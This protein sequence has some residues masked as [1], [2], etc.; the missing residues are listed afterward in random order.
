M[1][2]ERHELAIPGYCTIITGNPHWKGEAEVDF[3]S[4][5]ALSVDEFQ[6]LGFFATAVFE[7][8]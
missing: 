3:R 7:L 4:V 2:K 6:A 1:H 8:K 5:D